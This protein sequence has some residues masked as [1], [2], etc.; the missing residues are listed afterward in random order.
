MRF[1]HLL[2]RV[3]GMP[4]LITE[5]ALA[6]VT[7]LLEARLNDT[8]DATLAAAA[9]SAP[10]RLKPER[11]MG[12]P[13]GQEEEEEDSPAQKLGRQTDAII[14]ITGIIGK[15]VSAIEAM[16]GVTDVDSLATAFT[17]AN[18]DPA[19]E[20]I[21]LHIDSP[22]GTV[23]GV[24]E[25]AALIAGSKSKPVLAV[26]DTLIGS[27]AYWLAAAADEIRITPTANVGSIGVVAQV[28]EAIGGSSD[29]KT[30][31]RVFRSG[32]HKMAGLDAPLTPEQAA[33]I[34]AG[35]D[36][37]GAEFRAF[38][39]ASRPRVPAD[40]MQGLVYRGAASQR[41]GLVDSVHPSLAAA[42]S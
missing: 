9:S 27:A 2:S 19:V 37:L 35:V 23:T 6:N 18:A 38:V 20:R 31:L 22:G 26:S 34:Q 3:T 21:V 7:A 11:F 25:L 17:S 39:S 5:D 40:A 12:D 42:L 41:L 14:P 13:Q 30:R 15:R 16:C 32:A 1:L 8:G 24:P 4:W 29:G 28:R 33:H 10:P 36:D